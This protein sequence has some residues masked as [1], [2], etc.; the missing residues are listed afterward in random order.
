MANY[1]DIKGFKI[2]NFESDPVENVASWSTGG[3]LNTARRAL[4]GGGTQTAG[5]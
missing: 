4:A 5:S 3:N 2:A 1:R